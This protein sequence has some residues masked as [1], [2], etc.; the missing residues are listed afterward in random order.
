MSRACPNYISLIPMLMSLRFVASFHNAL[1]RIT[2]S[3]MTAI[4]PSIFPLLFPSCTR[5]RNV[6][7][8]KEDV[9]S[10]NLGGDVEVSVVSVIQL[11]YKADQEHEKTVIKLKV[12][13]RDG[14]SDSTQYT[15][16]TTERGAELDD[17]E[18]SF[19]SLPSPATRCTSCAVFKLVSAGDIPAVDRVVTPATIG[20]LTFEEFIKKQKRTHIILC[21]ITLNRPMNL[22]QLSILLDTIHNFSSQYDSLK[23]NCYWYTFTL[24]EVIRLG[25]DGLVSSNEEV[26]K[27]GFCSLLELRKENSVDPVM[28]AYQAAWKISEQRIAENK[29]VQRSEIA[30]SVQLQRQ[31]DAE[32]VQ[33]ALVREA[34]E[35]SEQDR[36]QAQRDRERAEQERAEYEAQLE[37][38]LQK[39]ARLQAL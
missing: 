6:E 16:V 17:V 21:K 37:A 30:D 18:R 2:Q 14:D 36:E 33:S 26:G 22:A 12:V 3:R 10:A 24:G 13:R 4:D 19:S 27:R 25:F 23:F 5:Y 38:A 28:V 32:R 34:L 39:L 9:L 1:R 20:R 31:L 15:W 11:K 8:W 29:R 35:Q 7:D